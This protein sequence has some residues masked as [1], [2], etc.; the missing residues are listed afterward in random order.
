VSELSLD[1]NDPE[2]RKKTTVN[3]INVCAVSSRTDQLI[4][5]FSD[6]RRLNTAVAWFLRLKVMLK[7]KVRLR[8]QLEAAVADHPKEISQDRLKKAEGQ[9]GPVAS[10]SGVLTLEDQLEA[11]IRRHSLLSATE[12]Q[13]GDFCSVIW[14]SS[15]E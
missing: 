15:S 2:V 11:E 6:W 3:A 7:A 9:Q 10:R 4:S 5:Y 14:E 1:L 12:I 13:G 8:G